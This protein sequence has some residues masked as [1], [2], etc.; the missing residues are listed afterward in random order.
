MIYHGQKVVAVAGTA[1]PLTATRFACSTVTIQPLADN[2]GEVRIGGRLVSAEDTAI[3]S[4]ASGYG[5][6]LSPGDSGVA[7]PVG[8]PAQYDL[9]S[10]FVDAD[11]N[12]EGVQF[13]AVR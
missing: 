1:E 11:V 3:T 2:T 5:L 9:S 6:A 10:I 4:I 8:P 7:F 13:I 12:G